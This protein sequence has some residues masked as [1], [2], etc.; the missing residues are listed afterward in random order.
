MMNW[1]PCLFSIPPFCLLLIPPCFLFNYLSSFLF[2]PSSF[3]SSSLSASYPSTSYTLLLSSSLFFVCLPLQPHPFLLF[4]IF[5][6]VHLSS[7]PSFHFA[8]PL[9]PSPPR[10]LCPVSRYFHLTSITHTA[11]LCYVC[12]CVSAI[13]SP[14]RC[15]RMC[16]CLH[17]SHCVCL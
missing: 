3:F 11:P 4:P 8:F 9:I 17:L 13:M 10:G 16:V 7:L 5:S 15:L 12:V 2:I 14:L 6:P 1:T